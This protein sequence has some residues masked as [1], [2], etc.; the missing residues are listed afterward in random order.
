MEIDKL[1]CAGDASASRQRFFYC[2]NQGLLKHA[3]PANRGGNDNSFADLVKAHETLG[4][5]TQDTVYCFPST[6]TSGA[7]CFHC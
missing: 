4:K 1:P 5:V 7:P 6:P 3:I 2:A